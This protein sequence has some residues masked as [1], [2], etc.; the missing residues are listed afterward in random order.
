S[1]FDFYGA[2]FATGP[3]GEWLFTGAFNS[4]RTLN[5]EGDGTTRL[6]R[7][8]QTTEQVYPVYGDSSSTD[9]TTSSKDSLYLRLERSPGVLGAPAD[10]LMWGDYTT[11][12]FARPS[13]EFSA[14]SRNLHGFKT[15]FTFGNFQLTG[16]FSDDTDGFQ[17]DAIA[18]DGTSGFYFLS[19]QL[20]VPGTEQIAI[21]LEELL[22]PGTVV[23]RE[24]LTRGIDYDID[25]D[26]G[27][28]IFRQPLLR[29]AIARDIPGVE[30]GETLV[31]RIV[32]TYQF[33]SDGSNT[34]IYGGRVVYHFS[35]D[36]ETESW[37]GATYFKEN[38]GTRQFELYG[39]D[40]RIALGTN[41][42]LIAEY[43][44]SSNDSSTLGDI[45]GSAYR[46]EFNG[47]FSEKVTGRAY[48]RTA[49][50]GFSND[51]TTSFVPGQTRYGA[52]V[53][54]DFST[55]TTFRFQFD[56]EEN[57]GTAPQVLTELEDLLDPRAEPVPGQKVDNS[58]TTIT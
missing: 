55:S 26:R 1:Q 8:P 50:E 31:R 21:E 32:A 44:H 10:F 28:L 18:P 53:R 6:F 29:T 3:V 15:N 27:S 47:Q 35:R 42:E 5:R 39:V 22:R 33:E 49:E 11:E 41:S 9:H 12:E 14:V 58:L 34:S 52:E 56:R 38:Q 17:R 48:W 30:D 19:R 16:L 7:G 25:Y 51:A 24:V 54:A 4:D 43:A 23:Q 45:S 20:L 46:L 40:A 36:F 13:Q 37:L 57:F 2:G